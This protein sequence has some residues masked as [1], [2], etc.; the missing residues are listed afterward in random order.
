[1]PEEAGQARFTLRISGPERGLTM[2]GFVSS[3]DDHFSDRSG[4]HWL[5]KWSSGDET[6]TL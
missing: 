1:M 5:G 3:P 6:S 2:G 4:G